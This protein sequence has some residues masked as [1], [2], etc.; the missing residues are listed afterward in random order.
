MINETI[1]YVFSK[2]QD[3]KDS[4][5]DGGKQQRLEQTAEVDLNH[6]NLTREL[7][8]LIENNAT[9]DSIKEF[10]KEKAVQLEPPNVVMDNIHGHGN[11]VSKP[12]LDDFPLLVAIN[13]Q[14]EDVAVLLLSMGANPNIYGYPYNAILCAF[15]KLPSMVQKLLDVG[16]LPISS[17]KDLPDEWQNKGDELICGAF[18]HFNGDMSK[19]FSIAQTIID[20]GYDVNKIDI[21][22]LIEF[23]EFDGDFETADKMFQFLKDNSYNFSNFK[24]THNVIRTFGN[25]N[26]LNNLFKNLLTWG[27]LVDE[28]V[29]RNEI[30]VGHTMWNDTEKTKEELFHILDEYLAKKQNLEIWNSLGEI[31]QDA[32][33]RKKI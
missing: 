11:V 14:R 7:C 19:C 31:P 33:A 21:N 25:E 20:N 18:C 22:N 10:I 28:N 13:N 32:P 23:N 12:A 26:G 16:A 24:E 3:I 8:E 1:K 30:D 15:L 4:Y 27:C 17:F 2:I 29:L 9:T 6:Q 5:F